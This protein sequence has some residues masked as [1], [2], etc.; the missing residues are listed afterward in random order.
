MPLRCYDINFVF[1]SMGDYKIIGI[2]FE[3]IKYNVVG[4]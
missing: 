4:G 3:K 2:F 1:I